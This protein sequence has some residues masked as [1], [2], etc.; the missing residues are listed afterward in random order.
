MCANFSTHTSFG[1]GS[2]ER[3]RN[4]RLLYLPFVLLLGL[5]CLTLATQR[6]AAFYG[7]AAALGASWGS[8]FGV[9]FYA[10]WAI[11]RWQEAFGAS[12]PGFMEQAITQSQALFLVPQFVILA[13]WFT[14]MKRLK[15]DARLHGPA[16]WATEKEIRRMGYMDGKGVY[17]GGW[18][19]RLTGFAYWCAVARRAALVWLLNSYRPPVLRERQ[20]YLRHNGPEHVLCFAPTRSGKGVGL[21]L[22]TLLAWEGFTLV[23]DIKGEN[24]ALTAGF[25]RSQGQ[26][27]LRFDPSDMSGASAFFNPL[28]EIRLDSLLAISDAQNMASM[29]VDPAGK[30]LEDHWSKAAFAMLAG[31]LLHCCIMVRCKF[32]RCATLYDLSCMLADESRTIQDL[33]KEMVDTDHAAVLREI[34]PESLPVTGDAGDYGQKAH[35]FIAS[36]A[37]EMLN[38]AEND[39]SSSSQSFKTRLSSSIKLLPDI[40]TG[41]ASSIN[42]SNACPLLV[43][44]LVRFRPVYRQ[45]I[46]E[47]M[48][49]LSSEVNYEIDRYLYTG[50]FTVRCALRLSPLVFVR[51]GEL[52]FAQWQE[53]D[54]ETNEWRNLLRE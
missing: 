7:Y 15:G 41:Y 5:V 35:I 3:P 43:H 36:S 6:V 2:P 29:L 53:I 39:T 24:W 8:A 45:K 9:P 52:A 19:K 30:G 1:L 34:F 50:T 47:I 22:P 17:V 48:K 40:L 20:M 33:F 38:K 51:P 11:F 31:A 12:D 13:V 4:W 26:K 10:P 32:D 27:V 49:F 46:A 44:L 23:L 16:R 21:I 28:A 14:F 25:R 42:H 37:R 18:V 54:F